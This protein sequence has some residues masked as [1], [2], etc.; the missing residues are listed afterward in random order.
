MLYISFRSPAYVYWYPNGR[1]LTDMAANVSVLLTVIFTV[2]RYIG[3]CHP[4]RGKV[5][6][7]PQRAKL[8][9]GIVAL[10][11]ISL[12]IPEFFEREVSFF[13]FVCVLISLAPRRVVVTVTVSRR[14]S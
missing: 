4:M 6:C 12:T 8:V 5:L 13:L 3:V 2:E 7:T 9:T 10:V 14:L 11:A 1:V